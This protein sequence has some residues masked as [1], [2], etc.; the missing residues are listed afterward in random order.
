MKQ[1]VL[2]TSYNVLLWHFIDS[3]SLWD[4]FVSDEIN[5]FYQKRWT[6][7]STDKKQLESYVAVRSPEGWDT[8]TELFEWAYREFPKHDKFSK[9]L[10]CI[11]H[12]EERTDN[13][14][15]SLKSYLEEAYSDVCT[16]RDHIEYR[17]K[18]ENINDVVEKLQCLFREK[19]ET[20]DAIDAYLASS[21]IEKSHQGGANGKGIY[22]EIPLGGYDQAYETL[23]H[24]YLHRVITPRN[25]F[26]NVKD[27]ELRDLYTTKIDSLYPDPVG[28][29]ADEV[30]I[31]AVANIYLF[32][33][34][35]QRRIERVKKQI[36]Q[37][38]LRTPSDLH[39]WNLVKLSAPCLK[40]YLEDRSDIRETLTE[41]GRIFRKYADK[42][43][44]R[45]T[46]DN[47]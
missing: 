37:G 44:S 28:V 2:R 7:T 12:F 6:L 36:K 14:G 5:E 29:L 3:L 20:I 10:P 13:K 1:I 45:E 40:D 39:L 24:E 23:V 41:I 31:H 4:Y 21:P 47:L 17:M 16:G 25:Y 33:E 42:E 26:M 43:T 46:D 34:D 18:K 9:L 32:K 8:E 30:V 22:T 15:T 38:R 11:R 27:E 19:R 35:P